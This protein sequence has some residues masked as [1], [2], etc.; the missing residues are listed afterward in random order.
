MSIRRGA[1]WTQGFALKSKTTGL[2]IDISTW[3]LKS[4]FQRSVSDTTVYAQLTTENG[5]IL[6][7]DGVNGKLS[8]I[9]NSTTTLGFPL[10]RV[11]F[12][13]VRTDTEPDPGP[14]YVFGG[15]VFVRNMVSR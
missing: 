12:D 14:V 15:F 11:A 8:F 6:I 7:T 9:I 4:E 13:V 5:G 3:T 1:S 2:P 10:G